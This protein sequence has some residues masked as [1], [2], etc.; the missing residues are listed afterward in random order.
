LSDQILFKQVKDIIRTIPD[1]REST[2]EDTPLGLLIT[3]ESAMLHLKDGSGM[4]FGDF[5]LNKL[6]ELSIRKDRLNVIKLVEGEGTQL[7]VLI[8]P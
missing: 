1:V 2:I 6:T 5:A 3:I 8:E 4:Q 7:I